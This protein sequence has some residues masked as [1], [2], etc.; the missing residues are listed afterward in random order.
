MG[1]L[2]V[3]EMYIMMIFSLPLSVV[4]VMPLCSM[5]ESPEE[6]RL[7]LRVVTVMCGMTVRRPPPPRPS[8]MHGRGMLPRDASVI[9][10]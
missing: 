4:I 7:V 1:K 3:E 6:K 2:E 5:I 10:E 8:G 9:Y